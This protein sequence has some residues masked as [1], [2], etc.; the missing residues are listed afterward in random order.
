MFLSQKKYAAEI[1]KRTGLSLMHDH[2]EPHLVTL[3]RILRYDCGTLDYGL[4]LYSFSNS[5]LF[6]YSDVDWACC[7]TTR[8]TNSGYC[9][10]LG[11]NLLSWSSKRQCTLSLFSAKAE[12]FGVA[13]GWLRR[14][15][16]EISFVSFILLYIQLPQFIEIITPMSS[17]RVFHMLYLLSSG[18]VRE[19]NILPL[20]LRGEGYSTAPF[21]PD[22]PLM[23]TT[24]ALVPS[25]R[26]TARMVVHVQRVMSPSLSA[27]IAE[28]AAISNSVF[29][30]RFSPL[31]IVDEEKDDDEEE[32][33]EIEKNLDSNRNEGPGMRVESLGLVGDAAVPEGQQQIASVVETTIGKPLGLGYGALRRREIALGEGRM[34]NVFEVG[35]TS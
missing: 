24:P 27:S 17:S 1:F 30:K 10:F 5:L 25:L 8:C 35:Q 12:Y 28:V 33:E 13:T 34:P 29:H 3:K 7:L 9:V 26:R 31:T 14:H 32:D 6:A 23:H 20:E 11:N 18:P 16:C 22:H 4:Q 19:F 21:S 2:R 15:G